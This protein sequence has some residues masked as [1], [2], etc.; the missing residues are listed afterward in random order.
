MTRVFL[1]DRSPPRRQRPRPPRC[2]R[3]RPAG[4]T[5]SSPSKSAAGAP[6]ALNFTASHNTPGTRIK[7]HVGRAPDLPAITKRMRRDPR[8]PGESFPRDPVGARSGAPTGR[9][10]AGRQPR[11]REGPT[12]FSLDFRYG[13]SACS[14]THGSRRR[15]CRSS[16]N[17][18]DRSSAAIRACGEPQLRDGGESAAGLAT[19]L[20]TDGDADRFGICARTGA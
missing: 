5:P 16:V 20:A 6:L 1:A 2:A 12:H 8:D 14:W 18:A 3:S 15:G 11:S 10:G 9:S 17:A 19:G 4:P 7:S 13:T